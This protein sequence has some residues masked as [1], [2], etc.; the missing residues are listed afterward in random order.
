[1]Y[2][3]VYMQMKDQSR[4]EASFERAL[5][6]LRDLLS[7]SPEPELS[8]GDRIGPWRLMRRLASAIQE[9]PLGGLCPA[10]PPLYE[11][12]GWVFW[13]GPL[14]IRTDN[15]LL[16]TPD[17]KIMILSL[18]QTPAL[19]LTLPLSAEWREGELW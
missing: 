1:M 4:A 18:P 17:D 11:R 16:S 9:F 5:E 10:E 12:L 7:A 19:D 2:G 3:L 15:G 13:Q 6:P 8:V 14:F